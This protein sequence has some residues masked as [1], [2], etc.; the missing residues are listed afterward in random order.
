MSQWLADVT[1][2]LTANPEWLGL[3]IFLIACLE[4]LAIAGILVPGTILL[5]AVAVLAGNGALTL[6]QTLALAYAGG[7]L[8]DLLS[9]ATGRYFHQ[10]IRR[11]PGLR[12]HPEWMM[13]AEFYFQRYG[14][15]SLLVGR[16][17]GRSGPI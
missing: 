10:D 16:Y 5:F 8:G 17:I 12:H 3:A 2:W 6:G 1:L 7:V 9:Y 13:G 4:C 15:A 11:L 14:I